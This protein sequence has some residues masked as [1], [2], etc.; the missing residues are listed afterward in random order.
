M[1]IKVG[2]IFG[3]ESVEH[4]VSIISAVQAMN[5]M[6]TEK[7]EIV[8]IYITKDRVWYTGSMLKEIEVYQD[9]NLLKRYAKPVVLYEKD[10]RFV[11]QSKGFF[12]RQINEIDIAFPIVHGTNVEDGVLQGYL[13]SIGI[14][15]V[16][17]DVY[18]S[19]V[20]QDKLFMKQIF[21]S[22]ELPISPYT[23][24]YDTEYNESKEEVLS[25]IE[26][27]LKYPM[28]IKPATLGSSVG[29]SSAKN[30][31]E[32]IEA[33]D[34]ACNYDSKI[35]VE[36]M[37]QNLKEVN[38]SVLGNYESQKLSAIEQV[39]SN[40]DFLTYEEKYIGNKK[41]KGVKGCKQTASKGMASASR[42]VPAPLEK[43]EQ[44]EI[45]EIAIKAFKAL[46]SS[47]VCRIDFL[48]DSKTNKVYIN[49]I[50][51]IPGSLAFYLWEPIGKKYTELLDD[52][53]NIGIKDYKKRIAKVH[54]FDS[55]ILKGFTEMSGTKGIKETKK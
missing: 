10:G 54:S 41:T 44:N 34:D 26:N 8:P 21:E 17:G 25:K 29:I 22:E 35:I 46:G 20:G 4:E 2:V 40:K 15:F 19:V 13:Q 51:S 39:M 16:G 27:K 14:P 33:I 3:G 24:F 18:S 47:G 28:I 53:I 12:K 38:I 23:W 32:L 11:L 1:K 42:I 31:D 52:M 55:N 50:N 9:L 49:E 7:Y 43:K 48:I 5:K 36:E 30:K 45:E 6:D 37:V